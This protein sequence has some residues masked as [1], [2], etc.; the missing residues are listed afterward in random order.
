MLVQGAQE[1]V[2]K[3]EILAQAF[4]KVYGSAN[5]CSKI[6]DCRERELAQHSGALHKGMVFDSVL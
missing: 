4:I 2:D 5:L 3:A 1:A 6:M